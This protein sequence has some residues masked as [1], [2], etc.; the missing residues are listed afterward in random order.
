MFDDDKNKT[1]APTYIDLA[2]DTIYFIA[3]KYKEIAYQALAYLF[4]N[5]TKIQSLAIGISG[6]EDICPTIVSIIL[7]FGNLR[8]IM[9]VVGHQSQLHTEHIRFSEPEARP[10]LGWQTWKDVE[11][12]LTEQCQTSFPGRGVVRVMEAKMAS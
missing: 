12:C 2:H 6:P 8:E 3:P 10:W 11:A 7:Y 1:L 5:I 9:F 4:P